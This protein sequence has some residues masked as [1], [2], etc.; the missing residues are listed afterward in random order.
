[1][2][3]TCASQL[4]KY[5]VPVVRHCLVQFVLVD[6][7]VYVLVELH[8]VGFVEVPAAEL[9]GALVEVVV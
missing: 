9:V 4:V 7:L 1:M 8:K 3:P 2:L 5:E 6:V